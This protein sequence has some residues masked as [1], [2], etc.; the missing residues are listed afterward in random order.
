VD[1]LSKLRHSTSVVSLISA[2]FVNSIRA[3]SSISTLHLISFLV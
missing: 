2:S 3:I 1:S